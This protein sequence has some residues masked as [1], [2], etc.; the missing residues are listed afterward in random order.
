[1]VTVKVMAATPL[2]AKLTALFAAVTGA[3]TLRV[4]VAAVPVPALLLVT[5]PVLLAKAPA[6]L[7]VTV[8]E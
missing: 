2:G 4:A 3:N 8:V 7:P 5:G 1:M 6:A